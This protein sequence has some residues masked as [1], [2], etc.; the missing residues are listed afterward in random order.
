MEDFFAGGVGERRSCGAQEKR[1]DDAHGF[2]GLAED[3]GFE[4]FDVDGDVWEFG[5][6]VS[7]SGVPT[8][9]TVTSYNGGDAPGEEAARRER[10]RAQPGL[11]VPPGGAAQKDWWFAEEYTIDCGI[12]K[13]LVETG[14]RDSEN[15]S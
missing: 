6:A 8:W 11:A 4:G 5:H 3:A 12:T 10:K 14:R 2:E 1:A 13:K 15:F 9:G 7:S